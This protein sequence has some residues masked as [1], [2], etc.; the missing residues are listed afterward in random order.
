MSGLTAP[1]IM[2]GIYGVTPYN[3]ATMQPYGTYQVLKGSVLTLKGDVVQLK[4]G[5]NPYPW[6]NESGNIDAELSLQCSEYPDFLFTT[7][8]GKAPTSL[9]A[10]A[11]G[12]VS[13][14][15]NATGTLKQATTGIASVAVESSPKQLD[16]K[17]GRYVVKA[18]GATTVD[19]YT[20][21]ALDFARGTALTFVDDTLKITVTPLTIASGAPVEIPGT[22]VALMG[23][24]GTIALNIGD[25]AYFD[26]RPVSSGVSMSVTVGGLS[27]IYPD[28]GCILELEKRGN[29]EMAI[30]DLFRTKII[31]CALGAQAKAY[32][33]WSVTGKGTYDAVRGGVFSVIHS[34]P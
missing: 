13:T 28:F 16:L 24:S 6:A 4:G 12:N 31:G 3:I 15:T 25:T 18:V 30:I 20:M 34:R 11:N 32:S 23:G 33:E 1:R 29:G 9:P 27:D 2:Y 22:G 7:M 10:E 26:V 21:S 8:M 5:A 17:F 14:L 19:V